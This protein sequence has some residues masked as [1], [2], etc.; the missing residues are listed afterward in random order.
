MKGY[1]P[2][3][4]PTKKYIKAYILHQLGDKPVINTQ[5]RIGNKLYDVLTK[6]TN[7]RR[8]EYSNVR[9]NTM[10]KVYVNHHIFNHQGGTLNET[11]IKNF[12]LFME[13]EIKSAYRMLMDF[14]ID[15]LP[16]FEA[17]LPEVRK[18]IGIDLDNWDTDSIKKDY[19]RYRKKTGKALLYKT[20]DDRFV[21]PKKFMDPGF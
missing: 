15:L 16:S 3:E 9:Y 2:I 7:E 8:T 14:Y 13:D 1:Y 17:N 5:H 21:V 11:N 18:R 20:S 12:N 19:Y 10:I 4:I 6:T